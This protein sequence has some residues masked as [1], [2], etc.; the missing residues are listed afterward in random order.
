MK[1]RWI[2]VII[3]L[4]MRLGSEGARADGLATL[5]EA[6]LDNKVY[7]E[8]AEQTLRSARALFK[9]MLLAP[10][11]SDELKESWAALGFD[12]VEIQHLGE[13]LLWLCEKAGQEKGRGVY[14]FRPGSESFLAWQAPHAKTDIRTGDISLRLFLQSRARAA[15][16]STISRKQ[17]DMA[18]LTNTFF[19]SFTL[20][21]AEACPR[22]ILVQLHGFEEAKRQ[23]TAPEPFD[24]ILSSGSRHHPDWFLDTVKRFRQSMAQAVRVYPDDTRELGGTR[25]AQSQAL[26][27]LGHPGFLHLEMSPAFRERLR[28]SAEA[29]STLIRCLPASPIP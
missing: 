27:Q 22:G 10:K 7:A 16:W 4:V 29:R 3:T 8:P 11:A 14:L 18:H 15:A 12:W 23:E 2:A 9:R 13:N 6:A 1:K 20:A 17:A 21:F 28:Q 25:N 5:L 19:H 26:L 24:L